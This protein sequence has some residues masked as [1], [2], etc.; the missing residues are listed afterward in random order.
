MRGLTQGEEEGS[1]FVYPGSEPLVHGKSQEG[2]KDIFG[3]PTVN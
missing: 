3:G 2:Q 1:S